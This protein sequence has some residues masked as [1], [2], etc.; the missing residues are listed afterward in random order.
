V[1]NFA[2]NSSNRAG[3]VFFGTDSVVVGPHEK[4]KLSST[5]SYWTKNIQL[6]KGLS[7]SRSPEKPSKGKSPAPDAG[8]G[9]GVGVGGKNG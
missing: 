1:A 8:V 2:V 7:R 9:V 5:P 6:V 3:T 4:L